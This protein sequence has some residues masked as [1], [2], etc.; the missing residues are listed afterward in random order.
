MQTAL[1]FVLLM[2]MAADEPATQPSTFPQTWL[3]KWTGDCV[4]IS[5]SRPGKTIQMELTIAATE[6]ADEFEWTITYIDNGNRQDRRYALQTVEPARGKWRIDERNGIVL[7][8]NLLGDTL[9]SAFDVSGSRL[10]STYRHLGEEIEFAIM[11]IP[12]KPTK[13]GGGDVPE[14]FGFEVGSVQRALLRRTP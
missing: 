11:V 6:K 10:I 7:P 5:A 12:E 13:T 3:G 14:V 9:F 1:T 8:A 4:A 2:L